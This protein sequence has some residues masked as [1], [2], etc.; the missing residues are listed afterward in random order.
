[1]N[2]T[3]VGFDRSHHPLPERVEEYL[4]L[5]HWQAV[6]HEIRSGALP[7]NLEAYAGTPFIEL[8]LS[9]QEHASNNA[10]LPVS[11]LE[12]MIE[13]GLSR[14]VLEEERGMTAVSLCAEY[15]QWEWMKR[16]VEEDFQVE[17]AQWPALC[18]IA[19]GRNARWATWVDRF[20]Q[21]DDAAQDRPTDRSGKVVAL[22]PSQ[23]PADP[24]S[25]FDRAWDRLAQETPALRD[26]V[27]RLVALGVDIDACPANLIPDASLVPPGAGRGGSALMA[28]MGKDD[29]EM[30]RALINAGADVGSVYACWSDP[31]NVSLG[32]ALGEAIE[33]NWVDIARS[34][35]NTG[36]G[37]VP[38]PCLDAGGLGSMHPL[39]MVVAMN[40]DVD[41]S[42]ML[43]LVASFMPVEN[44]HEEG[45]LC[46]QQA[47][48][49]NRVDYMKALVGL[50]IGLDV[51]TR[52]GFLP[53]HQA[54]SQ[55]AVEAIEFLLENGAK[56]SDVSDAGVSAA[57]LLLDHPELACRFNAADHVGNVRM[58]RR[59]T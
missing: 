55:G 24:G 38:V 34:I 10:P 54:C 27:L 56:L 51:R 26:A 2:D 1:M 42:E 28:A 17:T 19:F 15:G 40:D 39:R 48:L 14:G 16:L 49:S 23:S 37:L 13:N 36:E 30:A 22:H 50:G 18:A 52:N 12:A 45:M 46:M 9:A 3:V 41:R 6:E 47:A 5:A 29:R 35:L 59:R 32:T 43:G 31:Q 53:I 25:P 58:F 44:I 11:L 57:S 7:V 33:K 8:V 20:A 21:D 4:A